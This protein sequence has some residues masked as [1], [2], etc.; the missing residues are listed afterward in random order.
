M[1]KL[2]LEGN[3]DSIAR[4]KKLILAIKE[5]GDVGH[6]FTISATDGNTIERKLSDWDGDGN[7]GVNI[8]EE[9]VTTSD[10]AIKPGSGFGFGTDKLNRE[11]DPLLTQRKKDKNIDKNKLKQL[12]GEQTMSTVATFTSNSRSSIGLQFNIMNMHNKTTSDMWVLSPIQGD[13]NNFSFTVKS[14]MPDQYLTDENLKMNMVAGVT[15]TLSQMESV[16][17]SELVAESM[18]LAVMNGGDLNSVTQAYLCADSVEVKDIKESTENTRVLE[19]VHL[20]LLNVVRNL[21]EEK[22]KQIKEHV[23]AIKDI[24]SG[25]KHQG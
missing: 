6:S 3:E 5:H 18:I 16:E 22:A 2:I 21:T 8:L 7:S 9:G 19:S 14:T 1:P 10:L 11:K 24:L 25:K 4:L 23:D 17:E 15:V 12:T 20:S 13:G